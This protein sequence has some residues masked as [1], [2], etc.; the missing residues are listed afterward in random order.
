MRYPFPPAPKCHS[1][2]VHRHKQLFIL[3]NPKSVSLHI[4]GFLLLLLQR[5][6][7]LPSHQLSAFTASVLHQVSVCCFSRSLIHYLLKCP[8]QHFFR[9]FIRILLT[10]CCFFLSSL[11]FSIHLWRFVR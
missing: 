6:V 8:C 7:C 1:L 10:F 2:N 4:Y 9:S 3:C 11:L 5:L